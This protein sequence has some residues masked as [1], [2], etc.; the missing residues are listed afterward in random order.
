[1]FAN[2][3]A[4]ECGVCGDNS[5]YFE[6]SKCNHRFF[7]GSCALQWR[8]ISGKKE[9]PTCRAVREDGDVI[10]SDNLVAPYESLARKVSVESQ[11]NFKELCLGRQSRHSPKSH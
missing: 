8:L 4:M 2:I 11:R 5:K 1:M 6:L 3:K 9:C 10:I 7:C